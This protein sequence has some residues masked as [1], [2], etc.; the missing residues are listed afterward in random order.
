VGSD[1]DA[2]NSVTVP[3]NATGATN[4]DNPWAQIDQNAFRVNTLELSNTS[5]STVW[6]CNAATWQITQVEDDR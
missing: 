2:I 1:P 5:N 6:M 4:S 3:V